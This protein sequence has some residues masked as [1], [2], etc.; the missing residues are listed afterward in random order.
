MTFVQLTG[1]VTNYKEVTVSMTALPFNDTDQVDRFLRY[2][3]GEK[4]LYM[5]EEVKGTR[6]QSA[7][8]GSFNRR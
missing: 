7:D 2:I 8:A 3:A 1:E 6:D 5:T 4:D